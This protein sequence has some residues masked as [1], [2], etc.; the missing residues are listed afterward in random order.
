INAADEVRVGRDYM[1]LLDTQR[2]VEALTPDIAAMVP[3]GKMVCLR[4]EGD[5]YEIV[6]RFFWPGEGVPEDPVTPSAH[7]I[8]NTYCR[9]NLGK[10]Q[11]S[12][13]QVSLG[14]ADL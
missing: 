5:E 1:L 2:Q 7:S 12:G 9:E 8:H 13:R 4:A 6:S 11:M 14:G 3:L 10:T